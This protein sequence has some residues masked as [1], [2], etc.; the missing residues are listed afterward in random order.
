[1]V[2]ART[3]DI[4]VIG[5]QFALHRRPRRRTPVEAVLE[6]R[7]DRAIGT[8]ADIEA[9]VAGRL[10]PRG[11]VMACQAQDPDQAR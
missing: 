1:M 9:T 11:A 5:Q 4:G 8:G 10:Q 2:V 7:L 6:D 3:A